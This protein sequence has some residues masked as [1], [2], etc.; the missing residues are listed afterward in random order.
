MK[1]NQLKNKYPGVEHK[2]IILLLEKILDTTYSRIMLL[3]EIKLNE[4]QKHTLDNYILRLKKHEPIQYVLGSWD[5]ID[6]NLKV[7]SRALIP[8]PETEILAIEALNLAKNYKKPKILDIGC[9]TGCI[10]LYIKHMLKDADVTLCDISKNAISLSKENADKL[11]LD[12][13][14]IHTDMKNIKGVYDIIISNPPYITKDDMATLDK[15][16]KDYEPEN[17][18][19]GGDD[20]MEFYKILSVMHKNLINCGYL[21]V[22]IGINQDKQVIKLLENNFKK[23]IIKKDLAQIPRVISARKA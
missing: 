9:G 18:L 21:V 4:V 20:G 2:D 19:F 10:G 16:V 8:R 11:N 6:I 22:E 17:A 13:N 5:F 15:S 7:D 23:I 1:L 12:V 3:D 14:F